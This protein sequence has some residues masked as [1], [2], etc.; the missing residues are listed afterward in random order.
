MKFC[1]VD[2]SGLAGDPFAVMVGILVDAQRMQVTKRD[3][4]DLLTALSSILGKPLAEIHT[5]DFYSGNGV[6]RTLDGET[7][8]R[9]ITAIFEWLGE[10]KH[11]IVFSA[12]DT[13]TFNSSFASEPESAQIGSLWRFMALH[14]C[15]SLQKHFQSKGDNKGN[16][17]V[18]FDRKETDAH[19][20][21]D[22][23]KSPPTWTDQ[24]YA[25]SRK[26]ERLD[27]I[28]DVPYFGDSKHVGLIQLADFVSFFLRRH[29]EIAE[30]AIPP[31]YDKEL[32]LVTS[33]AGIALARAIPKAAMYPVRGRSRCADLFHKYAPRSVL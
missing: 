20:L 22:I 15:L 4:N 19:G 12:V 14:L 10:R 32:A 29:I 3:W 1:Y 16:T 6:W 28:I 33:W 13:A 31:K 9:I 18:I 25:R 5:S 8:S 7:R 21:I 30:N 11:S 27:Q 2:E 26:R 23:I 17:V 24:Y